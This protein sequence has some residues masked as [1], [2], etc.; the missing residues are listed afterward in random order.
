MTGRSESDGIVELASARTDD[1]ESELIVNA[2][3]TTI[4]MTG[5]TIF[6][7]RRILLEHLAE[8]DENDRVAE[9]EADERVATRSEELGETGRAPVVI[10]KR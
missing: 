2:E 3:H 4:H 5:K 6:E 8:I 9:M 10:E 1:V 7:V